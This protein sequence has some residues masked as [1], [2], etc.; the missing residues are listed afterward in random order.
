MPWWLAHSMPVAI[1]VS[2]LSI[3]IGISTRLLKANPMPHGWLP[4][5]L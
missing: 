1:S 4:E 2:R 5:R 3:T